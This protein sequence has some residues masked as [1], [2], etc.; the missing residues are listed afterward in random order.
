MSQLYPLKLK[1]I[2]KDKIWG[3]QKIKTVMGK[4]YYPL[5]NCGEM[6]VVS[7]VEGNQ[8]I[9]ENGFLA[10][11]ELNELVEV[12]MGDLVGEKNYEEYGNEFPVLIKFIDAN[13]FL[14]IQVHPDDKLAKKRHGGNGK[15]EMWYVVDAAPGSELISGFSQK[16][17]KDTYMRHLQDKTLKGIL[18]YEKVKAG[19]VFYIPAGRVHALGPGILLAEVQQTSDITYRIYDWDRPGVDGRMRELHTDLALDAI[20]FEV[21]DDYKTT[22]NQEKNK[23]VDLVKSLHFTTNLL[24]FDESLQKDYSELDSFVA[25]VCVQGSFILDYFDDKLAVDTGDAVLL[26]AIMEKVK[27]TPLKETKILEI[28]IS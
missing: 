11:N 2:F 15:T 5:H 28:Y 6:W 4:D 24:H 1:N 3:G 14:S 25:Y 13:D 21:H 22:Y 8:S 20:D 18:N 12:Y 26:P 16:V 7:G 19:D 27:L 10:D 23:T 17:D 9:I